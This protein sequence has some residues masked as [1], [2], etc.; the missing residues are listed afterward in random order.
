[1]PPCRFSRDGQVTITASSTIAFVAATA[2][3]KDEARRREAMN[4]KKCD[5]MRALYA[6]ALATEDVMEI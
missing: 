3:L 4:I 2:R 5:A 1:M 6:N